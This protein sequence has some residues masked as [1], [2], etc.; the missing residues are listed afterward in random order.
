MPAQRNIE[1][2]NIFSK[3]DCVKIQENNQE[4]QFYSGSGQTELTVARKI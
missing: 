2:K 3:P 1:K 4:K